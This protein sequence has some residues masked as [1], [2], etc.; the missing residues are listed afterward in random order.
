M[1][2]WWPAAICSV[3][4]QHIGLSPRPEAGP[5]TT[6][7]E[8]ER[9]GEMQEQPKDAEPE[10]DAWAAVPKSAPTPAVGILIAGPSR[11]PLFPR[12]PSTS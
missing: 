9:E 4:V 3:C 11:T 12:G 5:P 8:R 1:L 10:Q 7:E 2:L 6:R